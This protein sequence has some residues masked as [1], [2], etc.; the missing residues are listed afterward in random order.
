MVNLNSLSVPPRHLHPVR[1]QNP[2]L[3]DSLLAD[4]NYDVAEIAAL[5]DPLLSAPK[6]CRVTSL[7]VQAVATERTLFLATNLIQGQTTQVTPI[8][9]CWL[10]GRSP[11]CAITVKHNTVSRCHAVI[12]HRMGRGLYITD[13]GSSNGTWVNRTRLVPNEQRSLQDGD[14]IQFGKLQVEFF[15]TSR[16]R[17]FRVLDDITYSR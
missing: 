7:Y 16:K 13:I 12:G 9:S 15:L 2:F 5:I 6:R 14:V 1:D 4:C 3:S 8:A 10:I 17:S 11:A